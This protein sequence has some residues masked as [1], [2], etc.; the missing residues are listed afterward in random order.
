[1]SLIAQTLAASQQAATLRDGSTMPRA[2][3]IHRLA[4]ALMMCAVACL[5][6]FLIAHGYSYYSLTL[7]DRP[8]SPLHSQLRSSGWIGLRLGMLAVGMFGVLFLYPLRK[9][10]RW[11]SRIGSTRR[12]LNVHVFFGISTPLVVTFHTAFKWHGL[13]GLAYWTMI[14]V[15]L[16]GFAGRYLYAKIPRSRNSVELTVADLE[17]QMVQLRAGLHDQEFFRPE[18]LAPLLRVPTVSEVRSM[19]LF[20]AFCVM[21]ALD[22]ARPFRIGRLRRRLQSPAERIST[23]GGLLA[24]RSAGVEAILAIAGRQSRLLAGAAFLDR[25]ARVFYLWHVVHRPFSISFVVLISVHI[26]VAISVGL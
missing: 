22:I 24:S 10:W 21:L 1:M 20:R 8:F 16:S 13:A 12:W 6:I 23:L 7:E 9:R 3:I 4:L 17:A 19:N 11:L 5:V 18:E 25:T 26:G 2:E 15:A 14:A